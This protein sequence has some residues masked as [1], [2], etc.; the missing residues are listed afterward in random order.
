[1]FQVHSEHET[2]EQLDAAEI[3]LIASLKTIGMADLNLAPGGAATGKSPRRPT[4]L[5]AENHP[6]RK[7]TWK[8]VREIRSLR[9]R[10][11]IPA[12][13]LAKKYGLVNDWAIRLTWEN[14]R[15]IREGACAAFEPRDR[16][17]S[18]YGVTRNTVAFVL[19]NQT[20]TDPEYDPKNL[21]PGPKRSRVLNIELAREIR[22]YYLASGYPHKKIAERF[23]IGRATTSLLLNNKT[24]RDEEYASRLND[25]LEER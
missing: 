6:M 3:E 19:S 18:R 10:R 14:V 16:I 17:G 11:F 25:R 22:E 7:L 12:S 2:L 4:P 5:R 24:W 21:A 1:M 15:E 8:Q 13:E 20:W 23:G 9:Q